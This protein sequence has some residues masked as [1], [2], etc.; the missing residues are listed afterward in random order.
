MPDRGTRMAEGAVVNQLL[1]DF[2]KRQSLDPHDYLGYHD[3]CGYLDF[4]NESRMS[5]LRENASVYAVAVQGAFGGS[6][7]DI[8]GQQIVLL[9]PSERILDR[10]QC[11]IDLRIGRLTTEIHQEPEAD[12]ARVIIR[13]VGTPR[14]WPG[15]ETPAWYH[16]YHVI[17]FRG[18]TYLFRADQWILRTGKPAEPDVWARKGLCRVKISEGKLSVLFPPLERP[19]EELRTALSL[20]VKYHSE[21][22]WNDWHSAVVDDREVV[23]NLVSTISVQGTAQPTGGTGGVKDLASAISVRRPLQPIE[24]IGSNRSNAIQ[25]LLPNGRAMTVRFDRPTTLT[26]EGWGQMKLHSRDFYDKLCGLLTKRTG[27]PVKLADAD[28]PKP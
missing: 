15:H 5:T 19:D 26:L 3:T 4:T 25:L 10:L 12:G 8:F 22:D 27:K 13:F 21:N 18:R 1:A 17:R 14:G 7:P 11:E 20:R 23:K 9:K 28:D 24:E 16:D 6:L 2:A